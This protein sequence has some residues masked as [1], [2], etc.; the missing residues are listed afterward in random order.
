[1]DI[2]HLAETRFE[3]YAV[4]DCNYFIHYAFLSA[5]GLSWR[6]RQSAEIEPNTKAFIEEI[7][8]DDLNAMQHLG[9][10]HGAGGVVAHAPCIAGG[11]AVQWRGS[12]CGQCQCTESRISHKL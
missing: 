12:Q 5:E 2:D 11:C 1:M 4:N 10:G 7:G 9:I 3:V 6:L 8:F